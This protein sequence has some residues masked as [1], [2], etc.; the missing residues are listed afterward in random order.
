MLEYEFDKSKRRTLK[1][2]IFNSSNICNTT[3]LCNHFHVTIQNS[4]TRKIG[5]YDFFPFNLKPKFVKSKLFCVN[6]EI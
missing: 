2:E 3:N 6:D 5:R 1:L 4:Q